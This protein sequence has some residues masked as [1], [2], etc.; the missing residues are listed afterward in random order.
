MK[1]KYILL[2]A[3]A[4]PLIVVLTRIVSSSVSF[5]YVGVNQ[6]KECHGED[7]IGNQYAIWASSPHGKA[8]T[9][10]SGEKAAEIA[11]KNGIEN[12]QNS[13]RCLRCHTTGRGLEEKTLTEGVGCEACHGPGSGYYR[14]SVHVDYSSRKNGY[15]RALKAGMYNILGSERLKTRERLCLSCHD[16]K[17]PCFTPVRGGVQMKK[18]TIHSID[19]LYKDRVNFRHPLRR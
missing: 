13:L 15:R 19:G 17:R 4:L 11:K 16:E 6:C 3:A 12:P 2:I 8:Y 7:A 1:K 5:T 9:L 14:A 18:L 10:L